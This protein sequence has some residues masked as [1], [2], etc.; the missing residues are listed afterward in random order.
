MI[1]IG[2]RTSGLFR[3]I[4][5][6][7]VQLLVEFV[8]VT[9]GCDRVTFTADPAVTQEVAVNEV[10]FGAAICL[11][12]RAFHAQPGDPL[13]DH[14]V[15]GVELLKPFVL[16]L[17]LRPLGLLHVGQAAHGDRSEVVVLSRLPVLVPLLVRHRTGL[18]R[19]AVGA[20]P[21]SGERTLGRGELVTHNVVVHIALQDVNRGCD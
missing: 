2:A 8:L 6:D 11:G 14:V 13:S 7:L 10:A 16:H 5:G 9:L 1:V 20:A 15:H 18:E 19:D 3:A 21:G 4:F 12:P 17:S